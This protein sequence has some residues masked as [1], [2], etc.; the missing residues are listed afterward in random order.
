VND[1]A[2]YVDNAED[3]SAQFNHDLQ[4]YAKS[5]TRLVTEQHYEEEPGQKSPK[6]EVNF[7]QDTTN[8]RIGNEDD[9]DSVQHL[10]ISVIGDDPHNAYRPQ[11][12]QILQ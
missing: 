6:Y 12:S 7:V 1:Y 10:D 2:D 5:S 9:V 3:G 8:V 11:G 4:G